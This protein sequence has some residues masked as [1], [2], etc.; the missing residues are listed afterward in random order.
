MYKKRKELTMPKSTEHGWKASIKSTKGLWNGFI[1]IVTSSTTIHKIQVLK[2]LLFK[3]YQK[4][5]RY[6]FKTF[7]LIST[8]K[9]KIFL[10]LNTKEGN[11]LPRKNSLL[12]S[13]VHLQFTLGLTL[14]TAHFYQATS[15]TGRQGACPTRLLLTKAYCRYSFEFHDINSLNTSLLLQD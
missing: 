9:N 8:K 12:S 7:S 1:R 2:Y 10:M 13:P 11:G 3:V 5:L 14:I 6:F 15:L 4:K